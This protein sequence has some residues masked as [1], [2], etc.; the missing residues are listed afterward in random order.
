MLFF[1]L[2]I[3]LGIIFAIALF[4]VGF[5]F[6]K[7]F[8]MPTKK[9]HVDPHRFFG[10]GKHL[11]YKA[12]MLEWVA[13]V[14]ERPYERVEIT[15]R[16]G[17]RLFGRLYPVEG[18]RVCEIFFHGWRGAAL[19]DGCGA[20][21]LTQAA[22]HSLLLVDQR[23]HGDSE[24]NVITFGIKE[25]YDCVDWARYVAERFGPDI[26]ILLSG[27][28][29]GA[30]TVLMASSLDLPPEVKGI[31]A[32]CGYT[33]PEAIIRK[34]CRDMGISDKIGYPFVR[35]GARVFGGFS[36]QDGGAIEA[37]KHTK[38]PILIIHGDD[39]DFVPFSMAKEIYDACASEKYYLAVKGAGHGLCFF[40]EL[41]TYRETVR[42]F[43]E[44]IYRE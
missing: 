35:L 2:G 9:K 32:D 14:E 43:Q 39:D 10:N 38:L 1:I 42:A 21:G 6:S 40:C 4:F 44:R 33:S 30:S 7:A 13:R 17:L 12:P 25:K 31:S 8:Y 22:G 15:S 36:I 24:G 16:D 28:S 19:R 41:D 5:S 34:V 23:A 37:V 11:E 27:I 18:S 3:V 26:K 29:M 20:A